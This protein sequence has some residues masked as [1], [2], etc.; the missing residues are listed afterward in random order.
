[1]RARTIDD[2]TR[3][4]CDGRKGGS[5]GRENPNRNFYAPRVFSGL[6]LSGTLDCSGKSNIRVMHKS[7][8]V[9]NRLKELLSEP[10]GFIR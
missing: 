6:E 10:V 2:W 8:R 5:D 9:N 1:M 7:N 3:Y 4:A